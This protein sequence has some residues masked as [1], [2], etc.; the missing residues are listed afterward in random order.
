MAPALRVAAR[1]RPYSILALDGGP[2]TASGLGFVSHPDL[3]GI[4]SAT[5]S[6]WVV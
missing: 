3:A 1:I 6:A 5:P 4:S 2:A